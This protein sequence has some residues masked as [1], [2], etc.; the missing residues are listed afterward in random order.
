MQVFWDISWLEILFIRRVFA[1]LVGEG[2]ASGFRGWRGFSG[3]CA[4]ALGCGLAV[5]RGGFFE[6]GWRAYA[7]GA[8][9]FD[10]CFVR[11][12]AFLGFTYSLI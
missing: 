7:C 9:R 11:N 12:H 6:A 4:G 3:V 5:L 8:L 2:E 10:D 1:L